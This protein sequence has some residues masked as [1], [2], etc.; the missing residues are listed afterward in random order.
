MRPSAIGLLLLAPH[1]AM[2]FFFSSAPAQRR[3]VIYPEFFEA[4]PVMT[5]KAVAVTGASRGLGYVTA[6][7]LAKKGAFV[8]LLSRPS[9]QSA[10]SQARIAEAARDAGSTAPPPVQVD[11]DLLDFQSVR[12]AATTVTE[13]LAKAGGGG[14]DVL[15]LNAG[16]ML[17]PDVASKDGYDSTA[18][19]N[20]LSHFLLTRA[21]LPELRRAETS[22][23]GEC[24]IAPIE[25]MNT[26]TRK[27]AN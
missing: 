22:R 7:S 14:L 3:S 12:A 15:C 13:L 5:G 24:P 21:L 23:G 19:T 26:R 11:C 18:S 8:L 6:L 9:A 25:P 4:L 2:A 16:I 27:H 10:E 17:Q 1:A 20:M